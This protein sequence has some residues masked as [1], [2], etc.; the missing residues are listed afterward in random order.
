MWV[1]RFVCNVFFFKIVV[2][3]FFFFVL[4]YL[5]RFGQFF[6]MLSIRFFCIL[7]LLCINLF[8][9]LFFFRF[10]FLVVEYIQW[11]ILLLI[12]D[13]W[14]ILFLYFFS[15]CFD[16]RIR[17]LFFL[18]CWQFVGFFIYIDKYKF[19]IFLFYL[20]DF[21]FLYFNVCV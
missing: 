9:Y 1:V 10:C 15:C 8:E 7:V 12:L 13:F 3:I 18:S 6:F 14:G 19:K 2:C 17:K 5:I 4:I 21:L 11:R 16:G 20:M